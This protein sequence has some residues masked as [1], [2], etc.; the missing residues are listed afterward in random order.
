MESVSVVRGALRYEFGMQLRRGSVWVV[1]ALVSTLPIA[2]W[3]GLA[4]S[5]LHAH[6]SPELH[7][8]LPPS[9]SD[10]ILGWAQVGTMLLPVGVGLVLA[11]R[12]A[13]DRSTHVDEILDTL[14]GRLG[15]RLLGKYLGATLA[16]LV[17]I[18]LI[19]AGVVAFIL[20]Q[21]PDARGI[22][23]A[24]AAFPAI[25]LRGGLFDGR[26]GGDQGAGLPV[27]V[28]RLLVLGQPDDAQDRAAESRRH[29]PQRDRSL[30]AGGPLPF[31]LGLSAAARD[32]R[33][34]LRQH[35]A[36]DWPGHRRAGGRMALSALAAGAALDAPR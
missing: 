35:C 11:D 19:Y 25:S 14:P 15:A 21:V 26:A 32:P 7:K 16:T 3:F 27:P 20:S 8:L 31:R 10:G 23:L 5:V 33:A 9:Q 28:P 12:L 34:G 30:G 18:A 29:H 22:P 13:R 36:T 2:L 4:G 6:Y 24:A 17:P 1:L